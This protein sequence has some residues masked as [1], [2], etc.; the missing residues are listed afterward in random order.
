MTTL[1]FKALA[2]LQSFQIGS[3]NVTADANGLITNVAPGSDIAKT[4]L[5][6][7]CHLIAAVPTVDPHVSGAVWNNSGTLTISAG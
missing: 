4:L 3:V 1:T 6:F 2:P 7:G 5:A